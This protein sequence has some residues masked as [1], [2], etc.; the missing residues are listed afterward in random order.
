MTICSC[1]GGCHQTV[2]IQT[3]VCLSA[4]LCRI[5]SSY[6]TE[7]SHALLSSIALQAGQRLSVFRSPFFRK[8]KGNLFCR[9]QC[10]WRFVSY[11][12]MTG[13]E[14]SRIL[15]CVWRDV[16]TSCVNV[17]ER[18]AVSGAATP[19][20]GQLQQK[21]CVRCYRKNEMSSNTTIDIPEYS[22]VCHLHCPHTCTVY[23]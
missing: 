2:C 7:T 6:R 14:V 12:P 1:A 19:V 4:I 5:F 21:C 11:D 9:A 13:I 22:H 17:R 18:E 20:G 10:Q 23:L 15:R 3:A 8:M 16:Y